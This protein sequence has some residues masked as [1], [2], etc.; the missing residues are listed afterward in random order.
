MNNGHWALTQEIIRHVVPFLG[1]SIDEL[2][3]LE[4]IHNVSLRQQSFRGSLS[5]DDLKANL[6]DHEVSAFGRL[7]ELRV[8]IPTPKPDTHIPNL[9]GLLRFYL[10]LSGESSPRKIAKERCGRAEKL[11]EVIQR[12]FETEK[13]ALVDLGVPVPELLPRK[14]VRVGRTVPVMNTLLK[15]R[16]IEA[17]MHVAIDHL[18]TLSEFAVFLRA[19]NMTLERNVIS[20]P[21][22]SIDRVHFGHAPR[23][24]LGLPMNEKSIRS[25]LKSL[26]AQGLISVTRPYSTSKTGELSLNVAGITAVHA[27]D[28]S[29]IRAYELF[30]TTWELVRNL[31]VNLALKFDRILGT[32]ISEIMANLSYTHKDMHLEIHTALGTHPNTVRVKGHWSDGSCPTAAKT[33]IDGTDDDP[34]FG[35]LIEDDGSIL[36]NCWACQDGQVRP[37]SHLFQSMAES[38][39]FPHQAYRVCVSASKL[40][41]TGAIQIP[42][43]EKPAALSTGVMKKYPCLSRYAK[44]GTGYLKKYLKARGVTPAAYEH[45]RVRYLPPDGVENRVPKTLITEFT[46]PDGTVVALRLRSLRTKGRQFTTIG[47]FGSSMFGLA[48]ADV[49][50]PLLVVEGEIDAE[51]CY[52]HGFTNVVAIGGATRK[53]SL[54]ADVIRRWSNQTVYLGLD[55]DSAGQEAQRRLIEALKSDVPR[56]HTV[57]WSSISLPIPICT[58]GG[59]RNTCKDAGDIPTKDQF[60]RVIKNARSIRI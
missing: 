29:G 4:A 22:F 13:L 54:I 37:M 47:S 31:D 52:S 24:S 45:F 1:L 2:K 36:Y 60:W 57:D 58:E 49:N 35:I 25:A 14:T 51:C 8:V 10:L 59:T 15:H 9:Y 20:C 34:S 28:H 7:H 55:C 11:V 42:E 39:E 17:S 43:F 6:P 27:R 16:L 53:T 21:I 5:T 18:S 50:R 32:T 30:I 56:L 38:S 12:N 33:H 26:E 40:V 41:R 46:N 19:V 48:Q 3:V 44:D 23:G